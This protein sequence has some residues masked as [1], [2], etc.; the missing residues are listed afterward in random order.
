MWSAVTP[1]DGPASPREPTLSLTTLGTVALSDAHPGGLLL[2]PGKPLAL[3]TYLALAPRRLAPREHLVDLLWADLPPEKARH[4]L[5]QTVWYLRQLLG[6]ECLTTSRTGEITLA[7]VLTSDRDQFLTA[8][9]EGEL[10]RAVAIYQGEFLAGFAAPGGVE[11]EH[12]ADVERQRLCSAFLRA[13]ETLARRYLD[14]G[15]FREAQQLAR[16]ARDAAKTTEAVWRLLLETHAAAGDQLGFAMEA[17]GL[18]LMLAAD[19]R[20]PEPATRALLSRGQDDRADPKGGAILNPALVGREREFAAII[21]AWESVSR[22]GGRHF[23]LSAPPGL[24]KSRLLADVHRR[25]RGLGA[26]VVLLRANPGDRS[27]PYSFLGEIA[28]VLGNLPGAVGISPASASSLVALHPALSSRFTVQPDAA[29]GGEALR[30][31]ATALNELL[32]TVSEE[33]PCALLLDDLHWA[34]AA[35]RQAIHPLLERVHDLRALILTAAR[36]VAA[37]GLTGQAAHALPLAPLAVAQTS[38]L[39][40][41]LGQL[42]AENWS[43]RLAE[44]LTRATAGSPLLLLET[45]QLAIDSG[46]V[47]LRDGTWRCLDPAALTRALSEGSALKHRV[48]NLDELS[49]RLLLILAVAGT[50]LSLRQLSRATTVPE[51]ILDDALAGLE[52]RGLLHR[53]GDLAHPAH[54]EIAAAALE[55]ATTDTI[56]SAHA[57]IATALLEGAQVDPADLVRAGRHFDLAGRRTE[58]LGVFARY[59]AAQRRRGDS[60]RVGEIAYEF[61][62]EGTALPEVLRLV[63]GL[64]IWTR[65]RWSSGRAALVATVLVLFAATALLAAR[66][67]A[68]VP[69]GLV[70]IESDSTGVLSAREVTVDPDDWPIDQPLR[71]SDGHRAHVPSALLRHRASNIGPPRASPDRR[72]WAYGVHVPPATDSGVIDVFLGSARGERRLTFAPRD[73]NPEDWS[74]DGTHLV[75]S[76]ARWSP[77]GAD[78][79]DLAV[80]DTASGVIHRLTDTRDADYGALWS[81]DGQ[82]IAFFRIWKDQERMPSICLTT[83]GMVAPPAC[84]SPDGIVVTSNPKVWLDADHLVVQGDSQGEVF[85]IELAVE[86]GRWR[87]P[88]FAQLTVM[89]TTSDGRWHAIQGTLASGGEV[90]WLV[91]PAGRPNALRRLLP[92]AP[93]QGIRHVFWRELRPAGRYLDSLYVLNPVDSLAL[94]ITARLTAAG[95]DQFGQQMLLRVPLRWSTT[96][97]SVVTVS[98]AGLMHSMRPGRAHIRAELPGWR[99]TS[100]SL[101]VTGSP[102]RTVMQEGWDEHWEERWIPSGTPRPGVV[103]G[104][105]R[106][107]ALLNNG[108]GSYGS[109]VVTRQAWPARHGLGLE[110]QLATP[111]EQLQFERINVMLLHGGAQGHA[112]EWDTSLTLPSPSPAIGSRGLCDVNYPPLEGFLGLKRLRFSAGDA[113]VTPVVGSWIREQRWW[114][115]RMQV[116]PDGRCGIAINGRPVWMSTSP[117]EVNGMYRVVLAYAAVRPTVFHGPLEVWEGVRQD[118]DWSVLDSL[119]GRPLPL[120]SRPGK[121]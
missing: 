105:G 97:S 49:L 33:Q 66:S 4:A 73:D 57:G 106:Q 62:G 70:V 110:I 9:E 108:D 53:S 78:D 41:S 5:R 77:Q 7:L 72:S 3:I 42:P 37:L 75:I 26:R 27:I 95:Q 39:L 104:P 92:S 117:I 87:R 113:S 102:A 32:T 88:P 99:S 93:G 109:G 68:P 48:S 45:L 51:R 28:R 76:T 100:L 63:R 30:H 24:G 31:R 35:S 38:E 111:V 118:I 29:T 18:S 61:L 114:T 23:H 79:Y 11:F 47:S 8:L 58:L 121:H 54:D 12:W 80:I 91:G 71:V 119:N 107:R 98:E 22:D 46:W 10:E 90:Q 16:R 34:D 101:E 2:A 89:T 115:L 20:E 85:P 67:F 94:G 103:L 96:D 19:Q 69:L 43:V 83:P 86:N 52:H 44:D 25:L 15:R 74:P 112:L 56:P 82:R 13:A 14:Q 21:A 50:P 6:P 36:P 120:A 1:D 17:S 81:P 40:A 116:M 60:R 64:P 59:L 84:L 55:V 65:V